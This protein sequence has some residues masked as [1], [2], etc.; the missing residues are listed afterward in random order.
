MRWSWLA[1]CLG[2]CVWA[3]NNPPR[4]LSFNGVETERDFDGDYFIDQDF[5]FAPG[6]T[7]PFEL[8]VRDPEGHDIEIWWPD[9]P[10]GFDF[11]HDGTSGAW[12]VPEDFAY[13]DWWFE[14]VIVDTAREPAGTTFDLWFW[15][16]YGYY[17]YYGRE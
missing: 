13:R 11:P 3:G 14:A 6:E 1:V 17:G 2:G 9:A 15:A 5:T 8:E 10:P 4:V 12:E 16:G 7:V